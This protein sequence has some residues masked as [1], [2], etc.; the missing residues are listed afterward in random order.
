MTW[1][2][3]IHPFGVYVAWCIVDVTSW[4]LVWHVYSFASRF[5]LLPLWLHQVDIMRMKQWTRS[6]NSTFH[7]FY[8]WR[9][10]KYCGCNQ[11]FRFVFGTF[12][13]SLYLFLRSILCCLAFV[14]PFWWHF[15]G[16]SLLTHHNV[17]FIGWNLSMC[18]RSF[19]VF[20][21]LCGDLYDTPSFAYFNI[22]SSCFGFIVVLVFLDVFECYICAWHFQWVLYVRFHVEFG[23]YFFDD[24]RPGHSVSV[25]WPR[26]RILKP[27]YCFE[28]SVYISIIICNAPLDESND[29]L[30]FFIMLQQIGKLA[31]KNENLAWIYRPNFVQ[32]KCIGVYVRCIC[33]V[34]VHTCVPSCRSMQIDFICWI[35]TTYDKA[36]EYLQVGDVTNYDVCNEYEHAVS[37]DTLQRFHR[38]H[39]RQEW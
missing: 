39:L 17:H 4:W 7:G 31:R 29:Q 5:L 1:I 8:W 28:P 18:R 32:Y 26:F 24:V 27:F 3:L 22:C 36:R 15:M 12:L 37:K 9:V 21:A 10:V 33:V 34:C 35:S 16:L 6:G 38:C 13:V 11:C 20:R 30:V 2:W 25:Y 19:V 14:W 23:H